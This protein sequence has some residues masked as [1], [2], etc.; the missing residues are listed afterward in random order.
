LLVDASTSSG[1]VS[2]ERGGVCDRENVWE[3]GR[4]G[5]LLQDVEHGRPDGAMVALVTSRG[6]EKRLL[7]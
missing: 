4:G 1:P 7:T 6:S 3:R 5:C 2:I